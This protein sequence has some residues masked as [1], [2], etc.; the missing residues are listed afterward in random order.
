[1]GKVFTDREHYEDAFFSPMN[2]ALISGEIGA[3]RFMKHAIEAE[4]VRKEPWGLKCPTFCYTLGLYFQVY[5]NIEVIRT[6]R[7]LAK[8]VESFI[9]IQ[10]WD[11]A[12]TVREVQQ[13]ERALD[14][15][16]ARVP[17]TVI[18]FDGF[19]QDDDIANQVRPAVLRCTIPIGSTACVEA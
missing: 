1:M 9:K 17:H 13:R 4:T 18:H 14:T 11:R 19:V 7:P 12:A 15:F 5:R 8:V 10:G 2:K 6:K 3:L 16:L